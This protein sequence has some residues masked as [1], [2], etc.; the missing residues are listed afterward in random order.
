MPNGGARRPC[1]ACDDCG[2]TRIAYNSCRNRHCP[3]CQARR[4]AQWLADRQAELLPVP[5]FHVVFTLPARDRGRR[6]PEQGA[7]Y[8][9]LFRT[10][11][12]TLTTLAADPAGIWARGSASLAVLHTWGSGADPPSSRPLHRPRRRTFARRLA[13]DRLRARASSCP[14]SVLVAAVPPPVP[15]TPASRLQPPAAW[16]SSATSPR[17]PR[18]AAFAARAR[19]RCAAPSAE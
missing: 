8:D 14:S 12:E 19:C 17:S 5:Y 11:A 16:P 13:M 18:R 3:K 7:V 1:R 2:A 9:L 15:R 6:L 4:G 10:A